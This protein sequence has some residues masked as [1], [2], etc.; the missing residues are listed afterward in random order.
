MK[1]LKR[2]IWITNLILGG[3]ILCLLC[4]LILFKGISKDKLQN[5]R[6]STIVDLMTPI[7][8]TPLD[9]NIV[10]TTTVEPTQTVI[11]ETTET[12]SPTKESKSDIQLVFTGDVLLHNTTLGAYARGGL[13]Q[14]VEK[15]LTDKMIAADIT[16]VNQEFAFSDGGTPMEN[17][18]Y[19]FRSSPKNVSIFNEMGID[20]VSLANNHTL[21]Y[22]VDALLDSFETLDAANIKYVGAGEN[23]EEAKKI[24]YFDIKGSRIAFVASSRVIPNVGWN[25]TK[26][27]PG[28]LTTYDPTT[29]LKVIEEA[30]ANADYVVI[31]VHWGV[32]YAQSP[33]PYQKTMARQYIDAGADAVVGSHTHSLQ[34]IEYYKE[35]PIIYSL[36]NFAFNKTIKQTALLEMNIRM[37]GSIDLSLYPCE[38][39][40]G[41]TT[42]ITE[43][44]RVDAFNEY[45]ES[46]SF[47]IKIQ[48]GQKIIW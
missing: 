15:K 43:Q 31:Y 17:K 5:E 3:V 18:K 2:G 26:S 35:K 16:M 23:L 24:E 7:P 36:G 27:K 9:E 44:A 20:I 13:D 32:E 39:K 46:I 14:M 41:R 21:D 6:N 33:Q 48:E 37:D 38:A 19:T 30:K 11:V 4:Y 25:A 29:T 1:K 40:N 22:G 47:G 8:T 42:M 10:P 12:P 45:M 28:M 34:G